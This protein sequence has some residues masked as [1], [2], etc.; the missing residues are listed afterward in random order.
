MVAALALLAGGD[1]RGDAQLLFLE[2]LE[3]GLAAAPPRSSAAALISASRLRSAMT[4]SALA[5]SCGRM[6]EI[7]MAL[8]AEPSASD[9]STISA[10]GGLREMRSSAASTLEIDG[11]GAV[12]AA[13]HLQFLDDQVA[14]LAP[15]ASA[16]S[17]SA[18]LTRC[19][20][21]D[22]R[23]V[24][25][26]AIAL[27]RL[28]FALSASTRSCERLIEA[29]ISASACASGGDV[30]GRRA[31]GCGGRHV[32][33]RAQSLRPRPARSRGRRR[34]RAARSGQAAAPRRGQQ[35]AASPRCPIPCL[36]RDKPGMRR[37]NSE[38]SAP[39]HSKR[40]G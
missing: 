26:G 24:L 14:E 18:S 36:R 16:T 22:Q 20:G 19:A 2:D 32:D 40:D 31:S 1:Q 38:S 10:G 25:A 33:A 29:S 12:E 5:R 27:H 35:R 37:T 34:R 8:R 30:R 15:R 39:N 3:I 11:V 17:V 9:G 4:S 28:D 7:R 13:A 6:A 23:G 21:G